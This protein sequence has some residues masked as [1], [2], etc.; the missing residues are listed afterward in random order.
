MKKALVILASTFAMSGAFAQASAP[1]AAPVAAS[2]AAGHEARTEQRIATLH[3]QLKITPAQE[4]QWQQFADVMRQ[5]GETMGNLY[6]Q[7]MADKNLSALDDMKQY[8]QIA[9][10]HADGMTKLVS[11]FEPLYNSFSADQKKL[12]DETFRQ[13]GGKEHGGHKGK[14][15][16]PAQPDAQ[17]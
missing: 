7:R 2:A 3:S 15:A 5:N 12:A 16:K 11:A 17:Q 14:S 13:R 8:T 10:A 6:R 4:T 1:A 9:Q